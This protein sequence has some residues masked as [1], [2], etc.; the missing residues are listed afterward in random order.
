MG[1][2]KT[3]LL[4]LAVLLVAV[5]VIWTAQGL[6][7]LEGSSMTGSTTWSIV[8]PV[9]AGIGLALGISVVQRGGRS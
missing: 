9:V 3:L 6:G 2:L 5:G 7:Y 8:G 1:V 4:V